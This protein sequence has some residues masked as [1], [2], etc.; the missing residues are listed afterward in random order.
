M[1]LPEGFN[2]WEHLQAQL[3]RLHNREVRDWFHDIEVDDD[4]STPRGSLKRACLLQDNDSISLTV[5]RILL[6]EVSF[7]HAQS[8]QPPVYGIPTTSFQDSVEF[9]PQVKLFFTEDLHEADEDYGAATAEISFRLMNETSQ[10]VSESNAR[11]I[12][13]RIKS[14]FASGGGY[15]WQ[16][17][18]NKYSYRDPQKGYHFIMACASEGEAREVIGKVLDIQ[19]HAPDWDLLTESKPNRSY[20]ANPGT[21]RIFGKTCKKPRRRPQRYV[22]FRYAELHLWGLPNPIILVDRTGVKQRPLVT[23]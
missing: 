7:K 1:P 21:Q 18:K 3:I 9:H 16:K 23:L 14:V 13:N 10:T 17:G 2:E 4:I 12:A 5:L 11:T 20:P 6:F 15:R 22:R 19:E 8:L